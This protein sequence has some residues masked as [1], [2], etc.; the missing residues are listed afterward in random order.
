M[1]RVQA[2]RLVSQLTALLAAEQIPLARAR[3]LAELFAQASADGVYSHGVNRVPGLV[4]LLRARAIP[5]LAGDP[6][7]IASFGALRR[8]DGLRGLGPLNAEFCIDR[9][10]EL[11]DA[12][13]VGCVALRNTRHW[14][15]PG[16]Q[17]A[18]QHAGVGRC[19]REQSRRQ[20][21]GC[22]GRSG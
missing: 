19:P 16:N 11:A 17:H 1:S 10:M 18:A 5:E 9:A 21:S 6:Q 7:L 15:R 8:Y 12:H 20:Q 3:R 14:G 2:D 22:H 13:G 4:R